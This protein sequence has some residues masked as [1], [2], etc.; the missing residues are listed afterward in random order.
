VSLFIEHYPPFGVVL[1]NNEFYMK[2]QAGT[3]VFELPDDVPKEISSAS[4][5]VLSGKRSRDKI[6]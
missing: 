4:I 5:E 1:Q 2:G 6:K 3:R